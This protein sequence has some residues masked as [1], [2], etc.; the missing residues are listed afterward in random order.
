MT[1]NDFYP[2]FNH[3]IIRNGKKKKPCQKFS[4]VES[5]IKSREEDFDNFLDLGGDCIIQ[6][7]F[8]A[9][10]MFDDLDLKIEP[11]PKGFFH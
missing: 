8:Y 11:E 9:R 2:K 10:Q 1:K 4:D 3:R 5:F 7:N 6:Q